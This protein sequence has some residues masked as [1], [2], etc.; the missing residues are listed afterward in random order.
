MQQITQTRTTTTTIAA[1][2][3]EM[4]MRIVSDVSKPKRLK[5]ISSGVN[6]GTIGTIA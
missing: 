5:A 1:N 4:K 6:N 2:S 3:I